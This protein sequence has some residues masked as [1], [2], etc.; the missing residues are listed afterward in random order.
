[1]ASTGTVASNTK[2]PASP[3]GGAEEE[4]PKKIAMAK[5]EEDAT[6]SKTKT[7]FVLYAFTELG[8]DDTGEDGLGSEIL[9]VFHNKEGAISAADAYVERKYASRGDD[10]AEGADEEGEP[11]KDRLEKDQKKYR[12]FQP[13]AAIYDKPSFGPLNAHRTN[14]IAIQ[15]V[16]V[17]PKKIG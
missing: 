15:E 5:A 8:E 13:Y 11:L 1:M 9:G 7:M 12:G 6:A 2:R 3:S 4:E 10:Y 16:E 17:D 14:R